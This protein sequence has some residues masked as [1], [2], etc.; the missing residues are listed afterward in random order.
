MLID[1]NLALKQVNKILFLHS[2][3]TLYTITI[4]LNFK[5]SF[6]YNI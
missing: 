3:N 6:I 2:I 1:C 4:I 5:N